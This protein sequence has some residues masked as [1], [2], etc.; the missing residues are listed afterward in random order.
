MIS[1]AYLTR[2]RVVRGLRDDPFGEHIDLYIEELQRR[3]NSLEIG[4][5]YLS[6]AWD[7]GF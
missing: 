3:G 4:H 2:S 7:F 6:L 1:D 5:R